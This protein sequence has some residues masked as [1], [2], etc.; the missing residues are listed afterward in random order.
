MSSGAE[1]HGARTFLRGRWLKRRRS[2]GPRIQE[3]LNE[4]IEVYWTKG[5]CKERVGA[6]GVSAADGGE[7]I[8]SADDNDQDAVEF[9]AV[10]EPIQQGE[11]ILAGQF[12]I[13][14]YDRYERGRFGRERGGGV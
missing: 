7:V 12:Q 4:I 14:K 8:Q 10:L 1:F 3:P 9:F 11:P 2:A 5:F 13:Q 6:Q